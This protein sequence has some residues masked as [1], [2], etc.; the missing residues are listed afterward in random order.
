[1]QPNKREQLLI[2][3]LIASSFGIMFAII[4][5]IQEAGLI[6]NSE[7]LGVWKGV[8]AFVTGLILYWFLAKEI[9]GGPNDK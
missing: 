7:E 4:S 9:P 8:I 2:M 1:M 6:P 3:W 5:W